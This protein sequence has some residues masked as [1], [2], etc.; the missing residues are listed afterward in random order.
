[1]KYTSLLTFLLTTLFITIL[2]KSYAQWVQTN[3]PYEAPVGSLAS[4]DSLIF[5]S[6]I[7]AGVYRSTDSGVTW[8]P[9]NGTMASTYAHCLAVYGNNVYAGSATGQGISLSTDNGT[10]WTAVNNGLPP[11]PWVSGATGDI[12]RLT[13]SGN[14]VFL[15]MYLEPEAFYLSANGGSNWTDANTGAIAGISA[16]AVIG[17]SFFIG[18]TYG[19]YISTNSGTTWNVVGLADS[20]IT[21]FAVSGTNLFASTNSSIFLSTNNGTTWTSADSGL[22]NS[23]IYQLSANG[24]YLMAK[25]ANVGYFLSTNTGTSWTALNTA[26]LPAGA[27]GNFTP[28]GTDLYFASIDFGIFRSTDNGINWAIANTGLKELSITALA[29]TKNTAFA[30][31]AF[32]L[33]ASSPVGMNWIRARSGPSV[34]T[35]VDTVIYATSTGSGVCYSSDE[36]KTWTTPLNIGAPTDFFTSL[37]VIGNNIFLATYDPDGWIGLPYSGIYLSTNNGASWK[38]TQIVSP[39]ISTLAANGT[40]IYAGGNSLFIVSTDTSLTWDTLSTPPVGINTL[41]FRDSEIFIG[42]SVGILRSVDGGKHWDSV[43]TGLSGS[44]LFVH[45]LVVHGSNVFAGTNVGV[46]IL[47]NENMSWA[48]VN[49][50]LPSASGLAYLAATDSNLYAG[51]SGTVWERPISDMIT[52]VKSTVTSSPTTFWLSQNYPNPF[53]PSTTIDYQI[54]NNTL[55][56]LKVYDVLGRL[57]KTLVEDRQNSGTHSV[58]FNASSLSSGV[59]FYRLSAGSFVSTKKLML[60]K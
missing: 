38:M 21:A 36:G 20:A 59:Y 17:N 35:V 49:T 22:P 32:S 30:S 16:I 54:P 51:L 15:S 56:T 55:V 12:D 6:T 27:L 25:V 46:Y 11:N 7:G 53:N 10:T 2:P 44:A 8:T 23:G 13:V 39:N 9:S 4:G 5:A 50:G 1:M 19:V 3:G 18:S 43:N 52:S 31:T 40:N 41:A 37:A 48:A 42:S 60:I 24:S 33:Y 34:L 14:N 58:T 47:N 28:I 26:S 29:T 57:V 45:S